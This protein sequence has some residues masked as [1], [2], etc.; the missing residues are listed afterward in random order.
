MKFSTVLF[1]FLFVT[2]TVSAPPKP[3]N[4][5]GEVKPQKVNKQTKEE[6]Q[7]PVGPAATRSI[8]TTGGSSNIHNTQVMPTTMTDLENL[9]FSRQLFWE[10][11]R[12]TRLTEKQKDKREDDENVK[13]VERI[14]SLSDYPLVYESV[15]AS[16]IV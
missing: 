3:K 11:P 1:L 5:K 12:F 6:T 14:P 10:D 13:M 16:W 8:N 15:L 7:S 2:T 4:S 9:V